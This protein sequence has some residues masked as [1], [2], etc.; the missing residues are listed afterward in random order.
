MMSRAF[1]VCAF[2]MVILVIAIAIAAMIKLR[3]MWFA[4]NG[5]YYLVRPMARKGLHQGLA[6]AKQL[7]AIMF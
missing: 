5:Q 3:G 1:K 4:L 6:A 7:L 2:L